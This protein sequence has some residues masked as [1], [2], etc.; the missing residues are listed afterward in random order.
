LGFTPQEIEIIACISR[1]HRRRL[2]RKKDAGFSS[3]NKADRRAVRI[4]SAILKV[5]DGLDR[6]HF[7]VVQDVE[8]KISENLIE[9]VVHATG[10]AE[11]ELWSARQKADM[12]QQL[13]GREVRIRLGVWAE[14]LILEEE[15][16]DVSFT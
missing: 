9:V 11:L 5:A 1:Y 12:L 7:G 3:L 10:D 14:D 15:S 13:L 6:T 16:R 8:C 4:L 2:P